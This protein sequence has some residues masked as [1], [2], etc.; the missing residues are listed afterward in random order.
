[1]EKDLKASETA[2]LN[3]DSLVQDLQARVNTAENRRKHAE[4]EAKV[5]GVVLIVLAAH[6]SA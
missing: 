2:R 5:S 6:S 1:L 4:D 3:S